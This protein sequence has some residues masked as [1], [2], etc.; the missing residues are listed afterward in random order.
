MGFTELFVHKYR[1]ARDSDF[2]IYLCPACYESDEYESNFLIEYPVYEDLRKKFIRNLPNV[3]VDI[4]FLLS[5]QDPMVI[6]AVA[7]YLHYAFK[8]R[9]E[10][11]A[12]AVNEEAYTT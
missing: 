4:D 5:E 6:R 2:N 9:E 3:A 10:A 8:R 12:T 7:R 11:V 1:Y